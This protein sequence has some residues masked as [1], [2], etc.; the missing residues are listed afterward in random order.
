MRFAEFEKSGFGFR[1]DF[2]VTPDRFRGAATLR[3]FPADDA[4]F[5]EEFCFTIGLIR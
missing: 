3:F 5:E 1:P 4:G 2:P